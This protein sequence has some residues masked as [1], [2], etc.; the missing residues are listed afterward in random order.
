MSAEKVEKYFHSK[1]EAKRALIRKIQAKNEAL[2]KN[3]EKL[4]KQLLNKENEGDAHHSIDLHQLQIENNQY[5]LKIQDRNKELN[6]LKKKHGTINQVLQAAK[7]ELTTLITESAQLARDRDDR[8]NSIDRVNDELGKVQDEIDAAR[9]INLKY[10][11][12]QPNPDMPQVLDYV[13][14][15]SAEYDLKMQIKNW[16]RK[17]EIAEMGAKRARQFL[18]L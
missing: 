2:E 15:K 14:Q 17:V 13:N 10:I 5:S 8:E 1:N 16:E 18:R 7:D 4:Q 6:D 9:K 3:I 12:Q 11:R